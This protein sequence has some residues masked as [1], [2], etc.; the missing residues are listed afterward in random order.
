MKPLRSPGTSVK[1]VL[2]IEQPHRSPSCETYL[3]RS[4]LTI[5]ISEGPYRLYCCR[6]GG[7]PE[8][9]ANCTG[10]ECCVSDT[11]E[12]LRRHRL[13]SQDRRGEQCVT[14]VAA[15]MV[16][17]EVRH[18]QCTGTPKASAA[19]G[20]ERLSA[21]PRLGAHVAIGRTRPRVLETLR[22]LS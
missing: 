22:C 16:G 4:L 6:H 7:L 17:Q 19:K 20:T 2:S 15:H 10:H 12:E 18:A 11:V 5:S 9:F 8:Q 14:Q 13:S 1:V 3:L 21:P